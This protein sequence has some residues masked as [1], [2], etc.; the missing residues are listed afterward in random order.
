MTVG[1]VYAEGD[2]AQ[3]MTAVLADRYGPPEALRVG[4][5]TVPQPGAGQIQ[6]RVA[7][8]ALNPVDLR[9][10]GGDFRELVSLSFPHVP[11][12][13]VAGTVTRVGPG[14]TRFALGEEVFGSAAPRAA[15]ALAGPA[16]SLTTGTL[17]E[18]T[19]LE[20]D[21]A[22][23]AHR[24]AEL[25]PEPAT[26][27]AT[28]GLTALA[29]LR[30]SGARPG[31]RALVIGAG[32]GVGSLLLPLLAA[33]QVS[34]T[35]TAAPGDG[36][37]LQ[38]LGA[39]E[40][41]GYLDRSRLTELVADQPGRYDAVVNLALPTDELLTV[42]ALVQLGGRLLTCTDHRPP[43]LAAAGRTDI[44]ARAV[45]AR[46]AGPG[47]L[48]ELARMAADGALPVTLSRYPLSAGA[49]AYVDLARRHTA[50]KLV[51]HT[52]RDAEE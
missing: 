27:L 42:G 18:Y 28:A 22:V 39:A 35:A 4:R 41:V 1:S 31:Q 9:F 33:R 51:V 19:V 37:W 43:D 20:A 52:G 46:A 50:G 49:Q 29:L 30:A 13:D 17:A 3:A 48:A 23:V 5:V 44:D 38:A 32:G 11:G 10:V 26:A 2:P 40:L 45:S 6:V 14:V 7:A 25:G 34:V 24:P 12:G 47:D 36:P 21:T 15:R 8:A 16:P